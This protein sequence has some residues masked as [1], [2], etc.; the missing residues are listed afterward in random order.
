MDSETIE[1]ST[2]KTVDER[3]HYDV[4]FHVFLDTGA[5]DSDV[6]SALSVG[7]EGLQGKAVAVEISVGVG[8]FSKFSIRLSN[9]VIGDVG[10]SGCLH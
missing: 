6:G 1:R 8:E 2:A 10:C 5:D 4:G 3:R 7:L 9:E